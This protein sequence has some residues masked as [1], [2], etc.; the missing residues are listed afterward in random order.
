MLMDNFEYLWVPFGAV[1]SLYTL[2][3]DAVVYIRIQLGFGY[4]CF[5]VG[6]P[7]SP[8]DTFGYLW[9]P[10]AATRNRRRWKNQHPLLEEIATSRR[11]LE[12]EREAEEEEGREGG[13]S[14]GTVPSQVPGGRARGEGGPTPKTTPRSVHH[15]ARVLPTGTG[16]TGET[17]G[18]AL[19]ETPPLAQRE[20]NGAMGTAA[21][22]EGGAEAGG[23]D[24]S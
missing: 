6:N 8:L 18:Q 21:V 10:L 11:W 20:L 14:G 12:A 4:L 23:R 7:W 1:G 16:K 13:G 3:M 15:L 5:T 2:H 24:I 17:T 22:G 19:G 9:I